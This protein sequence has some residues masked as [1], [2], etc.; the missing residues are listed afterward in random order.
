M[1]KKSVTDFITDQEAAS[2]RLKVSDA[3]DD[4]GAM[5]AAGPKPF[6]CAGSRHRV[7]AAM[8]ERH[9]A[10]GERLVEKGAEERRGIHPGR[11]EILVQ[12]WEVANL[13]PEATGGNM[14]DQLE[15]LSK[16][17]AI[18]GLMPH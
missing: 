14:D 6:T 17:A 4:R 18:E 12:L 2:A 3:M 1:T 16:I 10:P 11:E 5:E 7:R 8:D 15:A 13:S 9:A